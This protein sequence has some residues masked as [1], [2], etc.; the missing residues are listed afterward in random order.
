MAICLMSYSIFWLSYI[1]WKNKFKWEDELTWKIEDNTAVFLIYS[2]SIVALV[3][4]LIL[5]LLVVRMTRAVIQGDGSKIP[6][7][8]S[9]FGETKRKRGDIWNLD[10]LR[11][12]ASQEPF[13]P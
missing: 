1:N 6:V 4:I 13:Y 11:A 2:L 8:S 10:Y 7:H 3:V 5:L 9:V 12:G